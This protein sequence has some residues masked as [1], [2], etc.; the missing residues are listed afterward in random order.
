MLSEVFSN[1]LVATANKANGRRGGSYEGMLQKMLPYQPPTTILAKD[2]VPNKPHHPK[3]R[4]EKKVG[5]GSKRLFK[6][7]L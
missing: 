2:E 1:E 7:P 5:S 6:A 3:R 4:A